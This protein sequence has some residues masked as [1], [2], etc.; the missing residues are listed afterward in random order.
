MSFKRAKVEFLDVPSII[1]IDVV[2]WFSITKVS[3]QTD[4][5]YKQWVLDWMLLTKKDRVRLKN[6]YVINL[7]SAGLPDYFEVVELS[8]SNEIFSPPACG[9]EL[10]PDTIM[11]YV[12]SS[13]GKQ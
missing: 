2:N 1:N 4:I 7:V 13:K 8:D 5:W 6:F 12:D 10:N 11:V 9:F 3:I